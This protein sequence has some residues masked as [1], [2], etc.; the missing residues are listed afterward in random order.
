[1]ATIQRARKKPRPYVHCCP[2]CRSYE[3]ERAA[4]KGVGERLLLLMARQRPY[5]CMHCGH[6]FYDRRA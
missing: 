1:M 5:R 3:V 4:R 2:K 6:R